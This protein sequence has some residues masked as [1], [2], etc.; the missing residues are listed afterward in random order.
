MAV[1]VEL[2]Y[3]AERRCEIGIRPGPRMAPMSEPWCQRR[4]LAVAV[5][6]VEELA[7]RLEA[8]VHDWTYWEQFAP[9]TSI[10][11]RTGTIFRPPIDR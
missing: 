1:K 8:H 4:Y 7:F 9:M 11:R 5:E 2:K 10:P 6:A 3:W